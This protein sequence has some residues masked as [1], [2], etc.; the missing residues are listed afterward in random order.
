[1]GFVAFNGIRACALNGIQFADFNKQIVIPKEHSD[2]GNL[3][4]TTLK[5]I[6]EIATA[7]TKPRNDELAAR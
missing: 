1:M 3:P 4:L 5:T 2:C 7:C 6:R